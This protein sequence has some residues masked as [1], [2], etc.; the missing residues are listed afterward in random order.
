[1]FRSNFGLSGTGN[2]VAPTEY[3]VA[4][5][6]IYNRNCKLKVLTPVKRTSFVMQR[7]TTL[8]FPFLSCTQRTE[9][10]SGLWHHIFEELKH[11][12]AHCKERIQT[13]SLIHAYCEISNISWKLKCF[14]SRLAV[15]FALCNI[16]KASVNRLKCTL[17]LRIDGMS[18]SENV[19]E[20]LINW[21]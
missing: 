20:E 19:K 1:M 10:L 4:H 7:S 5:E 16:L 18:S 11:N 9:I 12:T 2:S 8:G 14:L 21:K 3:A 13:E 17:Y 6:H 15:V